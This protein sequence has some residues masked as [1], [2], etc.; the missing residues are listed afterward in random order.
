MYKIKG[1]YKGEQYS[2]RIIASADGKDI[3]FDA[4]SPWG[5]EGQTRVACNNITI[6]TA[7]EMIKA[8]TLAVSEVDPN[9]WND[10]PKSNIKIPMPPVKEPKDE[11]VKVG[12]YWKGWHFDN[13]EK[14]RVL[15]VGGGA[16]ILGG[17]GGRIYWK[18]L[19]TVANDWFKV[20]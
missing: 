15:S 2:F 5:P 12:E 10:V 8:L 14:A 3:V 19:N 6:D 17:M 18:Y 1:F 20:S 16:V 9:A 11:R 13:L 4:T 7:K